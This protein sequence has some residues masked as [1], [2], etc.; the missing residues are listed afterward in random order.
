M[1][2]LSSRFL[3]D[4]VRQSKYYEDALAL[5]NIK[6][7]SNSAL[8]NQAKFWNELDAQEENQELDDAA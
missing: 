2:Q 4:A 5:L 3:K 6:A 1:E 7:Q 8:R